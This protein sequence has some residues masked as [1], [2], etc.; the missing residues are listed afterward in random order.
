M[1][2]TDQIK[3]KLDIASVI[4]SYIKIERSGINWK[5]KCPFHK[6]KTPSFFISSNRQSYYCFGCQEKGDI[7]SFVEKFEGLDFKSSLTMLADRAGVDIKN[8]KIFDERDTEKETIQKAIEASTVFFEKNLST[9]KE[10]K[11]YLQKRGINE[12]TIK[13][14]RIGFAEDAWRNLYNF[15]K[16]NDYDEETMLKAGLIKKVVDEKGERDKYYDTFR[17]RIMFPIADTASKI[18]AFSGRS[19]APSDKTPKYLNSP[20]TLVFHK[21]ETLHGFNHAKQSMR[22][23]DYAILVEGQIDICMAHQSGTTNTVASSGTALTIEHLEKINK[24]TKRIILAYDNDKAGQDASYKASKLALSI[25]M[26][27]KVTELEA[28]EDPASI[29]QKDENKWKEAIRNS[30]NVID[31][32][33]EK[34][35]VEKDERE[36][37][38]IIKKTVFPLVSLLESEIE[39]DQY[40]KK[41][42]LHL[43]VDENSVRTDF[44]KIIDQE[45]T[46]NLNETTYEKEDDKKT[47]LD[48]I[49]IGLIYIEEANNEDEIKNK[50]DTIIGNQKLQDLLENSIKE[51]DALM[52]EA[53]NHIKNSN[54]KDVANEIL[55]RLE[56]DKLKETLRKETEA[57]DDK[58]TTNESRDQSV[59]NIKRVQEKI[60]ELT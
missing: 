3:E 58:N 35:L 46:K 42:S 57:L 34:S 8:K 45:K 31:F 29:I 48:K 1:K 37:S 12:E 32:Y 28:G 22:K 15:L 50:Y 11:E 4:G 44:K 17:H 53:E 2:I 18:I 41:L 56:V 49:L 25:G 19:M 14:W 51:K 59:E 7:F 33:I 27:V 10:A 39:K 16:S 9:S 30:K 5:A 55:K 47:N 36:R 20:E 21:S 26:E 13:K 60:K 54:L 23:L 38:K 40:I 43:H 6:E 24:I 52:F